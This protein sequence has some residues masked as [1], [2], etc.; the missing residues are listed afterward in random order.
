M[1]SC[2]LPVIEP[3]T[4]K[5]SFLKGRN[6]IIKIPPARLDK[7]SLSDKPIA[8]PAVPKT[9]IIEVVCTPK[10]VKAVIMIKINNATNTTLHRNPP[11]VSSFV[12]LT[13]SL[14]T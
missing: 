7:E 8:K 9:A 14:K 1:T 3:I 4:T 10:F 11:N 2:T 5:S 13:M 12:N 6:T